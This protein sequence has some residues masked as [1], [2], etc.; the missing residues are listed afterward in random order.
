MTKIEKVDTIKVKTNTKRELVKLTSK[1]EAKYGR[2]FSID[3][4]INY[5][6]QKQAM[7]ELLDQIFGI[8]KGIN[9]YEVLR[10]ERK[11]T[12]QEV[13]E[14]LVLDSGINCFVA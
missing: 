8:A 9:L 11:A 6:L 7:P 3:D 10:N 2:K 13:E 1:L 4:A 14:S 5:L 12:R